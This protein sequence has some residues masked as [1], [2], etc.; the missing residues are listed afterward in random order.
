M[1]QEVLSGAGREGA[2]SRRWY[3]CAEFDVYVWRAAGHDIVM[4]QLCWKRPARMH[5]LE[6]VPEEV[7][8]W[9]REGGIALGHIPASK[10]Y[11]TPIVNAG[12]GVTVAEI[13]AA[14]EQAARSSSYPDAQFVLC[15]MGGAIE[16]PLSLDRPEP[17][18]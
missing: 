4:F 16:Q 7:L 3:S 10:G 14:F 15:H 9:S 1:L 18:A 17:S 11:A 5:E 6:E 2:L 12:A 13:A 8:N